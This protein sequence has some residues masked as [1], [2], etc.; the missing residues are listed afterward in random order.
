MADGRELSQFVM[1]FTWHLRN[2][3]LLHGSEDAS[4]AIDLSAEALG[5]LRKDAAEASLETLIRHIRIF[6]ELS[7]QM[8]HS[9][10]KR[11]L[12][13]VALIK[14]C[15]PQME[16][17]YLS[18]AKRVEQLEEKLAQGAIVAAPQEAR[19]AVAE[20]ARKNEPPKRIEA[21][22]GDVEEAVKRWGEIASSLPGL[23]RNYLNKAKKTLGERG[24]LVLEFEDSMAAGYFSREEER[25]QL[26][27]A[28]ARRIG[29]SVPILIREAEAGR[30]FEE[31]NVDLDQVIHMEITYED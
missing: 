7:N 12:L 16:Q 20:P 22:P 31:P 5:R 30:S 21:I 26:E 19:A 1:D 9:S 27:E 8:R 17:D 23:S 2:L 10:Q 29:G 6:S 25:R 13:E 11:V 4:A 18:L 28:V 24:E 3:L 15:R 14:L